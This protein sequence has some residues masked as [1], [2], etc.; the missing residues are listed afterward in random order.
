METCR[1]DIYRADRTLIILEVSKK[2]A[3]I[4]T[5]ILYPYAHMRTLGDCAYC[6]Y[7]CNYSR[8]PGIKTERSREF[9]ALQ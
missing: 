3:G 1:L 5:V 8:L 6:N 9:T 2:F 7:Y 4:K